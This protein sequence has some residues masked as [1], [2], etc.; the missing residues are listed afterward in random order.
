MDHSVLAVGRGV[1]HRGGCR[2]DTPKSGK[3]RAVITPPHIRADIKHHLAEHVG[4]DATC[5]V[6]HGAARRVS[7]PVT[8]PS[9]DTSKPH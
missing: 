6:V 7:P 1:T 2:I 3:P 4:T 9:A 5:A 8:P